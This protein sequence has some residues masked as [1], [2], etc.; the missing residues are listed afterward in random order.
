[1]SCD[2]GIQPSAGCG[3]GSGNGQLVHQPPG[4][5]Q[6]HLQA[7]GRG[8]GIQVSQAGHCQK[9]CPVSGYCRY[10]ATAMYHFKYHPDSA[11]RLS[12]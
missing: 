10:D 5:R 8:T 12:Q 6:V 7:V 9:G 4:V 3:R 2:P 1:M 11:S